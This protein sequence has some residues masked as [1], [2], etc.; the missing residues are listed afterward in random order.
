MEGLISM[1]QH[2]L[3]EHLAQLRKKQGLTQREVADALHV[4]NKTVSKWERGTTSPDISLLPAMADYFAVSCDDLLRDTAPK[5]A[6][7]DPQAAAFQ[8]EMAFGNIFA[9]PLKRY[10]S[11]LLTWFALPAVSFVIHN[12][13]LWASLPSRLIVPHAKTMAVAGFSVLTLGCLAYCFIAAA[14]RNRCLE[15]L[16]DAVDEGVLY[17]DAKVRTKQNFNAALLFNLFILLSG[18]YLL[19]T[20]NGGGWG[21]ALAGAPVWV[22]LLYSVLSVWKNRLALPE[23]ITSLLFTRQDWKPG[24]LLLQ[25]AMLLP[26][27]A[28]LFVPDNYWFLYFIP[29]HAFM[30]A[31]AVYTGRRTQKTG[32]A[33]MIGFVYLFFAALSVIA[34]NAAAGYIVF[35]LLAFPAGQV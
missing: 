3:G 8:N 22:I 27:T 32:R 35:D 31:R 26:I 16:E 21:T 18:V 19:L 4:S 12:I 24:T 30:A 25:T 14:L 11:G 23:K 17:R 1:T 28:L 2:G 13:L 7:S 9:R 15:R 34:L 33:F 20:R 10:K 6:E 5:T 29:A